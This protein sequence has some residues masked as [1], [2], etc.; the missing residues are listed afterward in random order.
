MSEETAGV[1]ERPKWLGWLQIGIGVALFAV[2]IYFARAPGTTTSTALTTGTQTKP[3]VRVVQPVPGTHEQNIELTGE[4]ALMSLVPILSEVPGRVI[5]IA[6]GMRPGG[7]FDANETLV[8]IDP[9][10]AEIALQ[11]AQLQ[12]RI[13]LA[14]LQKQELKGS[15][16]ATEWERKNPGQQAPP[17]IRRV[18]Q[19][20]EAK[21]SLV[22]AKLQIELAEMDLKLTNISLPFA[23]NVLGTSVAVG[24]YLDPS[25][26]VGVA[27]KA[28][29]LEIQTPISPT[30]LAQ[31]IPIE[32][33]RATVRSGTGTYE[34]AIDRVSWNVDAT[35]RQAT[36]FLS[37]V[38]DSGSE[39]PAPG[40]FVQV[41]LAGEDLTNAMLLPEST[42][43]LNDQVWI[44]R[45]GKLEIVSPETLSL[46]ESGWIVRPFDIADGIVIG[47]LSHATAG[48]EVAI[49]TG[50]TAE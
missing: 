50:S 42:R 6:P 48:M 19:I 8:Q 45:Q 11:G 34:A 44:V 40:T 25:T 46:S 28:D 33:R 12:H 30:D 24:Q 3:E 5:A 43:Q 21:E 2:A 1:K 9:Q 16:E 14:Q 4:V 35:T 20:A 41:H 37:F 38:R 29:A 7:S 26:T 22:G 18:P 39:L 49:T 31:L 32:D 17:I 10:R 13:A 36:L 15:W 47:T 27:Y 23:G